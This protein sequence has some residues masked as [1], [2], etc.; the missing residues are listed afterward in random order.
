VDG[1]TSMSER[2]MIA[3][4]NVL[5]CV[6]VI[7]FTRI[8][9]SDTKSARKMLVVSRSLFSPAMHGEVLKVRDVRTCRCVDE[10]V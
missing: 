5:S 4:T 7:Q 8:V 6:L 10:M 1:D 2:C 9:P 3:M